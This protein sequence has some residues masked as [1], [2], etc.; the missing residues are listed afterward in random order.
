MVQARQKNLRVFEFEAC[1]L[2]ALEP[3]IRKNAVLLRG[4]LLLFKGELEPKARELLREEGLSFIDATGE[5]TSAKTHAPREESTPT[6]PA[7]ESKEASRAPTLCLRRTIRSG[8]E[9][10]HEGD[11]TLLGRLNSG[12]ILRLKGNLHAFGEIDG[13]VECEGEYMI[14]GKGGQGSVLFGGEILD[15]SLLGGGLKQL[16]ME[17][18]KLVIKEIS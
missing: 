2:E 10:I 5:L 4:F 13:V 3:Y 9:I 7:E 11:V 6:P 1:S 14:L 16:Y 18:D 15:S 8:E 12:A 17:N